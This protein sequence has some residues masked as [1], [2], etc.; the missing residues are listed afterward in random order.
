M[1][2]RPS[3]P[4]LELSGKWAVVD[5]PTLTEDDLARSPDPHVL[6]RHD[7]F[8]RFSARYQFGPQRGEIDGR[9]DEVWTDAAALFFTFRGTDGDRE[10]FGAAGDVG[11]HAETD[12]ITGTMRYH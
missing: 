1:P 10:V 8:D 7:E 6:I 9:V 11:Y 5:L 4:P 12:S 2:R 3:R